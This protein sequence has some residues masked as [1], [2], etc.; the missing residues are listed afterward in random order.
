VPAVT[1]SAGYGAGGTP[2]AH[3]LA[4][5]LGFRLLDRAISSQVAHELQVS[6]EEA[7]DGSKKRTFGER[8]FGSLAGM[9]G[10]VTGPDDDAAVTTALI[11]DN[12]Q[13]F[14]QK[15]E[16][17]LRAAVPE[18]VVVLG[19]A[20]AC[21]LHGEPDVLTVRLFGSEEA[22]IAQGAEVEGVDVDTARERLPGVDKARAH[23]VRHLY[24][25]D[26]D[27]PALFDL[28]IN[29]TLVPLDTC[30]EIIATAF[31]A[32]RDRTA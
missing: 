6:V 25:C 16:E 31:T 12:D 8:F 26:I 24:G 20:G 29:S 9:A 10:G 2:V 18:G 23:Y 17:I 22:R 3:R 5:R 7:H 13:V 21:A 4:E 30:V 32:M 15:A 27:D 1:V 14:R 28:Q 19:R 11:N